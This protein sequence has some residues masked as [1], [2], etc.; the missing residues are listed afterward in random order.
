MFQN[1]EQILLKL[2]KPQRSGGSQEVK[3]MNDGHL[4]PQVTSARG[5]GCRGRW[6]TLGWLLKVDE[7]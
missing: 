2:L 5:P 6:V 4:L 1:R 7:R 3:Q